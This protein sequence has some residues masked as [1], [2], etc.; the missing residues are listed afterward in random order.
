MGGGPL[1]DAALRGGLAGGYIVVGGGGVY[2]DLVEMEV[3]LAGQLEAKV[4]S[5]GSVELY[6]ERFFVG[7]PVECGA[8]VLVGLGEILSVIGSGNCRAGFSGPCRFR[9]SALPHSV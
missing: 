7:V 3:A 6:D 1:T 9:D 8:I 2:L 4:P 5:L